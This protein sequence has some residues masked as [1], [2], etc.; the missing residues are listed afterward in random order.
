MSRPRRILFFTVAF[1]EGGGERLYVNLLRALD[2]E[3]FEPSL[4]CWKVHD[5]HFVRELP[6]DVPVVDLARGDTRF[7]RELP[8]L[9]RQTASA[10][11]RLR[12][13]TIMSISTEMNLVLYAAR[14]LAGS[15]ARIVL[16]EQ[17]SPS[18]W[19]DLI[20][21]DQPLRARAVEQGYARLPRGGL[22]VCVAETVRRDLIE[23]FGCDP[24]R[25]VT[26]PNPVDLERVRQLAAEPTEPALEG[27]A[28][29]I[30]SVG[31]FFPQKGYDVLAR[32]F[33][34]I[35]AES[36]ARLVLVGD[37]PERDHVE[38]ILREAGVADRAALVGY[39]ENPFP[40]VASGSVF[41]LPSRS[42]GFGYVVAEALALGVPIVSTACAGPA[43]ILDGGRYG[44][45]V[46]VDDDEALAAATLALLRD[47]ERR[48][49]LAE[50]GPLRAE[51]F[52]LDSVVAAYERV[53]GAN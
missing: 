20:R 1:E 51:E 19:L 37:G 26:I 4:L 11:R 12:P 48:R 5:S 14:K 32:G 27:G 16:N 8:R 34:R 38:A 36:D 49:T 53:L 35:A 46:P 41:V 15:S 10:I 17:G 23:R 52:G 43:D 30:V 33:A 13:D 39:R 6:A 22:V 42:E 50:A 31:R 44:E 7:R 2:R 21:A 25:L 45:L 9:L 29:T 18:A 40:Y 47:P 24:A 28:A 3:R